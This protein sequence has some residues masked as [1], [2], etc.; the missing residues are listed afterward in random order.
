MGQFGQKWRVLRR[1]CIPKQL[2]QWLSFLHS[3]CYEIIRYRV[4]S[5]VVSSV[6][7]TPA[8]TSRIEPLMGTPAEGQWVRWSSGTAILYL[9]FLYSLGFWLD[10]SYSPQNSHSVS[11]FRSWFKLTMFLVPTFPSSSFPVN[12]LGQSSLTLCLLLSA[13][14]FLV[15]SYTIDD[16]CRAYKGHDITGDIQQAI[17]EV[18]EMASNAF[19]TGFEE[20]ESYIRLMT[21]LFGADRE[22]HNTVAGYFA[23]AT[24]LGPA[25]DFVVICNDLEVLWEEEDIYSLHR[26]PMGV[27]R[28]QRYRW[29]A[30]FHHFTPCNPA[31]KSGAP[32]WYPYAYSMAGRLI[33]LCPYIL[34]EPS[35]RSLRPYKDQV[36][37][38]LL[39]DNFVFLPTVLLYELLHTRI[40]NR[41]ASSRW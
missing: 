35:R 23:K 4:S 38:G 16:S 36:F 37:N 39:I 26:D 7:L 40:F 27:W 20:D 12:A 25:D 11:C 29:F 6:L 17:D 24:S 1:N 34:D 9:F 31:R 3:T 33:Y 13:L 22:R 32:A 41:K 28:D 21:T 18:Q 5:H 8:M 30:G 19:A 10:G 15:S 14:C 2:R